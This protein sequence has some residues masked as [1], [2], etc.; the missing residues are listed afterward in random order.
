MIQI[1]LPMFLTPHL[2]IHFSH[3]TILFHNNNNNNSNNNHNNLEHKHFMDSLN[4]VKFFQQQLQIQISNS[5]ASNSNSN[6][7]SNNSSNHNKGQIFNKILTLISIRVRMD[8]LDNLI[9]NKILVLIKMIMMKSKG[10][11]I[12][13]IERI[14][15]TL[16]INL[17]IES[18]IN[19]NTKITLKIKLI[20]KTAH[21]QK[22]RENIK[23]NKGINDIKIRIIKKQ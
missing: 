13:K 21:H 4:L 20:I 16:I 2:V 6:S 5:L 7:H 17:I 10:Q 18:K 11:I 22:I 12:I 15:N 3:K 1:G 8:S 23:I 9:F 19:I 14:I